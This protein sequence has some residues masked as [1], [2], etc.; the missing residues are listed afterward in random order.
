MAFFDFIENKTINLYK[1]KLEMLAKSKV[2]D[3]INSFPENFSIY[4]LMEKLIILNRVQIGDAHSL[5][6]IVVNEAELDNEIETW[7]K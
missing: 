3:T 2:I 5:E 1:I 7:F 4:E 6:N